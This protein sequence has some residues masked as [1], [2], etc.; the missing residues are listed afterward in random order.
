MS[1]ERTVPLV[2][3]VLLCASCAGSK[4]EPSVANP[5]T[6]NENA[7]APNDRLASGECNSSVPG[8]S[9]DVRERDG[10]DHVVDVRLGPQ[11]LSG[12]PCRGRRP[13]ATV[14]SD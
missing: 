2:W 10:G 7:G 11:Q 8:A 1:L 6:D 9:L 4:V 13:A 3:A 14:T 5:G 12:V